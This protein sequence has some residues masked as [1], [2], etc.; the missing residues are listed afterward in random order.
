MILPKTNIIIREG[1]IIDEVTLISNN[2]N[3]TGSISG[4]H[5][6]SFL[7]SDD[8]RTIVFKPFNMFTTGE[9][10]YVYYN[11][12][13]SNIGGDELPSFNFKFKISEIG[14]AK[15]YS[16]IISEILGQETKPKFSITKK[17]SGKSIFSPDEELPEDFPTLTINTSNNPTDGFLFISP[18]TIGQPLGYLIIT[19]NQGIPVYYDKSN[20]QKHGFTLQPN[21]LLTY[22]DILTRRFYAMD[23]SYKIVDTFKTG[24][25]YFTDIHELQILPNG[26]ALL[27]AYDPQ[28]V[29]MDTIVVGGDSSAIVVGLII[30]ELD[31]GKNVVFQWRSWDHFS[32][33]DVTQ[34]IGLDWHWIDYV[35]GNA[36]ELDLDGNLLI[37]CRHMDEITK[38]DRQ[39]GDI[40]WRLGGKKAKNND[41]MFTNDELTFSHQHDIRR[42]SNGNITMFDNG[43][44]HSPN[45][46]RSVEYQ[47]D[48]QNYTASLVWNFSYE[49]V[50]YSRA[51]GNTQRLY[52]NSSIIGWGIRSE[53]VRAVTEV[54]E[55]GTVAFELSLPDNMLNYRAFRF[56]WKTNLFITDPDSIFFASTGVGDSSTIY[57]N[58]V[59][60]SANSINIT[61]FYNTDP[62][63]SVLTAVPF[64]VPEFS[65]VPIEVKFKPIEEGYFKDI[66]HIRSDTE[67]SRVAQLMILAGRTDSTIS[68]IDN[69][70]VVS[71]YR[72][73]QNYPNP[74]NPVTT[75]QYQIPVTE[76]V[77]IKVYDALGHEILTLVNEEIHAGNY[78]IEFDGKLLS[79]GIYF[80]SIQVGEYNNVKKLILLK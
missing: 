78:E 53:D 12:G 60:N 76:W 23:S 9:T 29:R 35:H 70:A 71:G 16:G 4:K 58:L 21:G 43:N 38:I 48:E 42:L 27:M 74:F 17:S 73:E 25:G 5:Q 40:I 24:N 18:Y 59:S 19:D 32:I 3:V 77:T 62:A 68:S 75:I 41:F 45:F 44:L 67:T 1:S 66:L 51:M 26:H 20:S 37:S 6:G 49:P 28:P 56:D 13:I 61:S 39:T 80:Y 47:L 2:L 30:Q 65:T 34:D 50:V 46:S 64:I 31:S 54:K 8:H 22:Y 33:F 36:I 69:Q 14:S 15:E 11:G 55:D 79:S 10:V 63:Y 72:L 57:F 7:L 52:N